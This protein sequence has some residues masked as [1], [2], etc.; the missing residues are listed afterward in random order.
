MAIRAVTGR[1]SDS[2]GLLEREGEL[3]EIEQLSE[4]AC[5]GAG[6]LLVVEGPAGAGKTCLVEAAAQA[7]VAREML[8]LEAGA[9][10]L[11]RE[12]GFGV[13]RTLFEGALAG[14][15]PSRRRSLLSGAASAAAPVLWPAAS[16]GGTGR[17]S[18]QRCSMACSG[19]SRIWPSAIG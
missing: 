1:V 6:A 5:S 8:V 13:V 9:S 18:R 19:L 15:R 11:E 17:P 12:L 2:S 16:G 4:R 10:E 14:A 3:A 7:G